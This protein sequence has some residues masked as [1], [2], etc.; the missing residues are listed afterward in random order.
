LRYQEFCI[1]LHYKVNVTDVFAPRE[2]TH[3]IGI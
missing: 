2:S 3:W 1:T